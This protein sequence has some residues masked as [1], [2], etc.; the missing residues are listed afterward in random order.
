VTLDSYHH[1]QTIKEYRLKRGMSQATL[2]EYW[3]GGAKTIR[4]VQYI[5]AGEKHIDDQ[6]TLRALG[7]IL[8]IPLW[9]FGLSEYNPFSPQNLPGRG[10]RM[11]H[12]TLDT[13]EKLVQNAWYTRRVAPTPVTDPRV[14]QRDTNKQA[15]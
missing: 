6:Q 9:R 14:A 13:V 7:D 3:P 5:E 11:F 4:Y 12:E 8:E 15:K 1:G 2:A 10:E